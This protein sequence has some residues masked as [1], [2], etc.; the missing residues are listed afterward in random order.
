MEKQVSEKPIYFANLDILRFIAAFMVVIA[1]AY[2]GW[3]GWFGG[4][5]PG[6]L[7]DSTGEKLSKFGELAQQGI[8]NGGFGVDVFF[9]ISGFL[10]T[11]LLLKEKEKTGKINYPKFFMRRAIR[12]WPAYFLLVILTPVFL[13][14][15]TP[16][17][18]P[19]IQ[20]D[21]TPT[22][23]FFNNFH[24]MLLPENHMWQYPFMHLWSICVE[25]HFYLFWPI[26][27][28]IFPKKHLLKLFWGTI[29]LS[30]SSRILF[31]AFD[32]PN[33]FYYLHTLS[34]VDVMA[35][36]ALFAY[37]YSTKSF[38]FRTPIWVGILIALFFVFIYL[39]I[40]VYSKYDYFNGN[41]TLELIL[42]I[43]KKYFFILPVG[44]GMAHFI[45]NK[46]Q[47]LKLPFSSLWNY[48][49]RI[50]YSV[51]LFSN[52]L[53]P[54]IVI[55]FMWRF[56]SSNFYLFMIMNILISILAAILVYHFVEK[57]VMKLKK[58]FEIIKT[59]RTDE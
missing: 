24:A 16:Y 21:Y 58:Y 46:N 51:Y 29:A 34:R 42:I 57:P 7:L 17:G 28:W 13:K 5:A 45:F 27:I 33:S 2:E 12:I 55:Q 39:N 31:F 37:Y 35:I 38:S 30:I 6:I 56:Q 44:L 25:E 20:P 48:L 23:L 43:F 36:G 10:I 50:S 9:L 15:S 54:I 53:I 47:Q 8:L 59:K 32:E 41:K 49:G 4:K 19:I 3:L 22:I 1:H 40:D 11:F 26:F 52:V 18:Q 14:Y